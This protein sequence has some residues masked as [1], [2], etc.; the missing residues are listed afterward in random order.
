MIPARGKSSSSFPLIC[1]LLTMIIVQF[2]QG[3]EFIVNSLTSWL[4]I[5]WLSLRGRLFLILIFNSNL[6]SSA[7]LE[8]FSSHPSVLPTTITHHYY[9]PYY[10]AINL[11]L[12]SRMIV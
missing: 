10:P 6:Q 9:P 1:H 11:N 4:S 3:A 5:Y 8:Q 2:N 12:C 7:R